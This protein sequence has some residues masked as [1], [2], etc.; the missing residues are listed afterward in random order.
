MDKNNLLISNEHLAPEEVKKKKKMSS[1]H[2]TP[3]YGV[4][5]SVLQN[6]IIHKV[7]RKPLIED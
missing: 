1:H 6:Q 2:S 7:K 4:S 3:Q 5:G